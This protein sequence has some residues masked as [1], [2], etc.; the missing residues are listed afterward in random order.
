LTLISSRSVFFQD[1]KGDSLVDISELTRRHARQMVYFAFEM[2]K[3]LAKSNQDSFNDNCAL[4]IGTEQP[5]IEV[6]EECNEVVVHE[7][8]SIRIGMN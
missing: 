5:S 8:M 4:R 7:Q 6:L 3:E 2:M 1:G